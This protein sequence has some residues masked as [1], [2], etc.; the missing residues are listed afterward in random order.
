MAGTSLESIIGVHPTGAI[1][2]IWRGD[3]RELLPFCRANDTGI[4][5]YVRWRVVS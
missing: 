3:E 5:P 2:L 1:P 4:I